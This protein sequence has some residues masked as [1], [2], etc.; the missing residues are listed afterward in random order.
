MDLDYGLDEPRR[1][2]VGNALW[3]TIE[4]ESVVRTALSFLADQEGPIGASSCSIL[5]KMG[6]P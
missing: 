3:L 1:T 5:A 6:P 4:E 2:T